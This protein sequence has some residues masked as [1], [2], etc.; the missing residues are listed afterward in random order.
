MNLEPG[1]RGP[2]T[3]TVS[4]YATTIAG[5][6]V[7]NRASWKDFNSSAVIP[8]QQGGDVVM[9]EINTNGMTSGMLYIDDFV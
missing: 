9:V 8:R 2:R 3:L 7:W 5:A 1:G 4:N 6:N